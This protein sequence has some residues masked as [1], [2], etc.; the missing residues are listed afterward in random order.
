MIG[1]DD[2]CFIPSIKP[3]VV[4][5]GSRSATE[6]WTLRVPFLPPVA[7]IVLLSNSYSSGYPTQAC[8]QGR[9]PGGHDTGR[10]RRDINQRAS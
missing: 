8:L 7:P 2:L 6:G 5:A 4:T 3:Q 9:L 10:L 1:I